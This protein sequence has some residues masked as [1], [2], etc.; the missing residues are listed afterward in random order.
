M[1]GNTIVV[2]CSEYVGWSSTY[3][4]GAVRECLTACGWDPDIVQLVVCYPE[5]AEALTT[6]PDIKHITFI[7]SETV[8]KK[9]RGTLDLLKAT[10]S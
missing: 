1:A 5:E 6:S 8:G 9:V 3:F 2:K 7:G 10:K 4:V